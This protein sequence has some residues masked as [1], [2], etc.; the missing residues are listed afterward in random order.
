[1]FAFEKI[2]E[3]GRALLCL[4]SDIEISFEESENLKLV[5]DN[6]K[7]VISGNRKTDFYRGMMLLS[8]ELKKG[9]KKIEINEKRHF[10]ELGFCVDLSRNAVVKVDKIKEIINVMALLGYSYIQL[11]MEDVFELP[12]YPHFGYQRG[13]YTHAE[14]KEIDDYAYEMGLEAIPSIQTLG[15]LSQYMKYRESAPISEN[16]AVLL[17]GEEKTYEFIET[18]VRTMRSCFRTNRLTINCDEAGGVGIS[19]MNKEK[20]YTPPFDIVMEHLSRVKA[21]CDKYGY[22]INVCGDLF[23][24]HLGGGYYDFDFKKPA[25]ED[26]AKIPDVDVIFW[27]YYHTSYED[28]DILIKGHQTLGKK[29]IFWGGIWLWCGQLPQ[30]EFTF[31]TMEPALSACLDYNI[32]DVLAAHY[33]DDGS[34]TPLAFAL[35]QLLLYSEYCFKGKEYKREA[36]FELSKLVF[37]FDIRMLMAAS[38]Y[39]YPWVEGLERYHYIWPNYMGKRI[40]YSDLFLNMTGTYEYEDILMKH[41]SALAEIKDSQCGEKWQTYKEYIINVFEIT[42]KKLEVIL[43]IYNN[44]KNNSREELEKISKTELNELKELYKKLMLHHEEL[45]LNMYKP[46]GWEELNIRYGGMIARIDYAKR[47][48]ENFACGKIS[49]IPE[50]D[51]AFIEEREGNLRIGGCMTYDMI[52]SVSQP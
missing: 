29:L 15:H 16:R 5:F 27:D 30:T 40:F 38:S 35:P 34:E 18:I 6:K 22:S 11:Y 51:E 21:I 4:P 39:H 52:K 47:V 44:Y 42:V 26:I 24:G 32:T 14:L 9:S 1:M 23:Y 7:A 13:R 48:L 12:G 3:K 2:L 50:L 28:Y 46:F 31:N 33:A 10:E 49:A 17:C 41:K 43:S 8:A 25:D 20:K 37:D 36:V 19:K 45:W